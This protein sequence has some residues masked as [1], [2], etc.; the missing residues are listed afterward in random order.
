MAGNPRTV[1]IE[2]LVNWEKYLMIFPIGPGNTQKSL[3]FQVNFFLFF[4]FPCFEKEGMSICVQY[5]CVLG[6]GMHVCM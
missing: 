1:K 3:I 5:L 2:F 4:I 6:R